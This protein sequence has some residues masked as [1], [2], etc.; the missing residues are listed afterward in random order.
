MHSSSKYMGIV[1]FCERP[2]RINY[3]KATIL[4]YFDDMHGM[5]VPRELFSI[6]RFP[7][8]HIR[9]YFLFY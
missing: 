9:F 1:L 3:E 8:F 4:A 6:F 7:L 2:V 5:S